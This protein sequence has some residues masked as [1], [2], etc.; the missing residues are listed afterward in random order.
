MPVIEGFDTEFLAAVLSSESIQSQVEAG[1]FSQAVANSALGIQA[2]TPAMTTEEVAD[3]VTAVTASIKSGIEDSIND[4]IVPAFGVLDGI[5][6]KI[7]DIIQASLDPIFALIERLTDA[8]SGVVGDTISAVQDSVASVGFKVI[9]GISTLLQQT[10]EIADRLESSILDPIQKTLQTALDLIRDITSKVQEIVADL[11]APIKATTDSILDSVQGFASAIR[12]ALPAFGTQILDGLTNPVG[13]LTEGIKDAAGSILNAFFGDIAEEAVTRIEPLIKMFED[14][15]SVNPELRKITAPGILPV[16]AIGGL[17]AGFALPMILSS[18]ASTALSPFAEKMRQK[19]N[20]LVRPALMNGTDVIQAWQREFASEG[21]KDAVLDRQGFPD[22]QQ[23]VLINLLKTRPGTMD[24][25]DYWRRELFSDA[26]ANTELRN[27][28]WDDRYIDII[29]EAA[30]PPPGVQ[31][32][33][34]MAVREVFSPEVAEAFGQFE[35]IPP[36]YLIWAKRIGLS[37]EWARNYWAAHWVLPSV[38]QG[39]QMLHRQII[40]ESDLERLFVALDV[41]PFWR[42]PLKQIAFRPFTRVDVRRM[43]SLN[44]LDRAG[45]LRAYSDLGFDPEKAENMTE[46]TVRWV[47]S[48]RKVEK[49]RERDLTKGDIIGLFNDGLLNEQDAKALLEQ[50]GFDPDESELLIRR[51]VL[52]ELRRDRKADIS[53]VVDQAK[54]KVLTFEEAQDRLNGLDLT[55]KELEKALVDVRRA[56]TERI[57]LPSKADIDNWRELQLISPSQYITELDNLGFPAKYVALFSEAIQLEEAQDL[58]AAEERAAKTAEPRSITKGQLD[59]LLRTDIIDTQQYRNGLSVLRFAE[60]AIDN[61]VT[62]I[63]VQIEEVRL[64][65]EARLARGEDAA[66]KEKLL[67]RVLLGKLLL[68][69]IINL[70]AYEEGLTQLGF[71]TESVALL[72]ELIAGKLEELKAEAEE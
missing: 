29:R 62:A 40:T 44:I 64:D 21:L 25:V 68:K 13:L 4:G 67:G 54:I 19:M 38:Q 71:S 69:E 41:M 43:F 27:L 10:R 57:R 65:A 32:L 20:S 34:R 15:L 36:Q 61:F 30:F 18:V 39:F 1:N 35:E 24:I 51:E 6:E 12:E 49:D 5:T 70:D 56:T 58:L 14:E 53:L 47:E 7:R 11:V 28:G 23:Q 72:I 9:E 2:A 3:V 26:E 17:M 8:V 60:P 45:V 42:E 48:T 59:S 16:A 63:T 52:Q 50:M 22:D 46:F 31:D 37:E 55:R 66:E 33:I